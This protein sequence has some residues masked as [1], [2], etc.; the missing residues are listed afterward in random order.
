MNYLKKGP[1]VLY[2]HTHKDEQ[3]VYCIECDER[4]TF[5]R[6]PTGRFIVDFTVHN[7]LQVIKY[8]ISVLYHPQIHMYIPS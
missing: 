8:N 6:V 3:R 5:F 4:Y 1:N 2:V 7:L